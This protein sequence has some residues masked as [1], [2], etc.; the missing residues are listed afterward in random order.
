M[1]WLIFACSAPETGAPPPSSVA[2]VEIATARAGTLTDTWTYRGDATPLE[3]AEL[4]AGASGA[5]TTVLV[6]EGDTI[7]AGQLLLEIDLG[8]PA[9]ELSA[10][11]ADVARLTEELAMAGRTLDRLQRAGEVLAANELDSA[12]SR[13]AVLGAQLQGAEAAVQLAGA[14]L[15][16]HRVKAPFDG[17]VVRR[18]V[19]PGDWVEPGKSTLDVVSTAA[20]EVRVEAPIELAG[21][22]QRGDAAEIVGPSGASPGRVAASIA[23]V[24]PALDPISRTSVVRLVPDEPARWLLP[25]SSVAVDFRVQQDGGIVVP[26]DA[27]VDGVEKRV[28]E[29]LDG[30]VQPVVVQVLA[31]SES[32]ALVVAEGLQAGDPVVVKGNERLRPGQS[33]RTAQDPTDPP[34]GASAGGAPAGGGR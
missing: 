24:V 4:A 34:Q 27:I 22:I 32:E 14:R 26:R 18:H 1:W 30:T 11:R 10:A 15:M 8:L 3:R 7:T 9:A 19:D 16:R 13:V 28:F 29:V 33:V 20:V 25:G 2:V 17:V 21:R 31:S 5:V 12:R 6:R 23:G